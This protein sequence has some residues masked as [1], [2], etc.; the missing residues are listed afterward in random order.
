MHRGGEGREEYI[1]IEGGKWKDD[2]CDRVKKRGSQGASGEGVQGGF[3]VHLWL[4]ASLDCGET[5]RRL[6]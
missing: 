2:T 1:C 5:C 3:R 6:P 4:S